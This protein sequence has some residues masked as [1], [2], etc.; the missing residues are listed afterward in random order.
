MAKNYAYLIQVNAANNN[1]KFY[2]ITE[3][4]DSTV[5]VR[6][7][8]V[9]GKVMSKDYGYQKN[10][11]SLK[12]EKETK[13]YEDRTAL[14]MEKQKESAGAI[15]AKSFEPVEDEVVQE[16]LDLLITSSR[17][18]M[19]KNY[20]VKA[21]E[22]TP[23]MVQEAENDLDALNRIAL[24][25]DTNNALYAFN[26]KLQEL[27]TDI[28]R[29]MG[30]VA[31]YLAK[32]ETDFDKIL[33]REMEM[34]D[35][36]KGAIVQ[37]KAPQIAGKG[38]TVLEA[39]NL[40]IRP[41]TYKEED[42]IT[43]HLGRDY[44]GRQVENRYVKGF[45]VENNQTRKAYE[46]YKKEHHISSKNVRLFYHGSKVENFYS[47]V[48]TG[49][50]L[51]PN[52]TVTGKMFGQ[53][54]YFAPECRKSLNYMDVRGSHWNS[55][56]RDTGLCAVY[57]VAL[58]KCYEPNRILGSNFRKEDL[59]KGADSVFASKHN[60]HLGLKNDEYIVF[61]Q[62][63]CTIKYLLEMS[64]QNVRTK[65]YNLD[66]KMLRDGLTAGF[67]TLVKTEKGLQAEL[68]LEALSRPVMAELS[69]KITDILDYNRLYLDYNSTKD[70]I[71]I[72]G[73][74]GDKTVTL[75]PNITSDDY[76][77]L[78][79]EMKKAFVE[80]ENDWKTLVKASKEYPLGKTVSNKDGLLPNEIDKKSK[81]NIVKE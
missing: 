55:G 70:T 56:K 29:S 78:T 31:D 17:E 22:I 2:E 79:R 23:K 77:F 19:Q 45:A 14:H 76:A 7:G 68:A 75:T 81:E 60:P 46:E 10:F 52:A 36:V 35:N 3:N 38:Q 42:Q 64:S 37:T 6:Y 74:A 44:D 47:I 43:T 40:S 50:S 18:F 4:D 41:V 25:P 16:L 73:A 72:K 58:G 48:K 69:S 11:W 67:D 71:T 21:T 34:L 49:L 12:E 65:E 59:P 39:Y 33:Q 26:E 32:T 51:N 80:C 1:N 66:R 5:S 20:T 61:D 54:L 63:A 15:E 9:G 27:F 57:S 28:P 30:R 24:N 53:G 13:G 62:N 8:R